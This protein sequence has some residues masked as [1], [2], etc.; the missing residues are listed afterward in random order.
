MPAA[1]ERDESGASGLQKWVEGTAIATAGLALGDDL[2]QQPT[3]SRSTSPPAA[4]KSLGL[5]P[6][7]RSRPTSPEVKRDSDLSRSRRISAA[8]PNTDSPTAVPLHFRRP[9]TSPGLARAVPVELPKSE[10]PTSPSQSRHR[11]Q[12]SN[13][14]EF[15]ESKEYRPLYLVALHGSAKVEQEANEELP[16]LPSSKTSSRAQSVEDLRVL[17]DQDAVKT[18][19]PIDLDLTERRKPTGLTISTDRVQDGEHDILDSQ[20]TTPTAEHF[21]ALRE[22]EK[23]PKPKYEFHSPSELLRDPAGLQEVPSSPPIEGLPSAESSVVGWKDAVEERSV[24][25]EQDHGSVHDST[26][27]AEMFTPTQ[28]RGD[29]FDDPSTPQGP[30]FANIVDQ[31]VIA[32]Y[33]EIEQPSSIEPKEIVETELASK[34]AATELAIESSSPRTKNSGFGDIVDA[35]VL[36]AAASREKP[37]DAA[38]EEPVTAI[39]GLE[40]ALMDETEVS[41]DVASESIEQP[42]E[43]SENVTAEEAG[44]KK[45]KNKKKKNKKGQASESVDLSAE[46]TPVPAEQQSPPVETTEEVSHSPEPADEA[47]ELPKEA[48]AE[49]VPVPQ[50]VLESTEAPDAAV[51]PLE[52]TEN[53]TVSA[54]EV[55]TPARVA[56][57]D[58]SKEFAGMSKKEKRAAKKKKKQQEQNEGISTAKEQIDPAGD[59][60]DKARMVASDNIDIQ[61]AIVPAAPQEQP[62]A[63]E[64]TRELIASEE[65]PAPMEEES[66]E[67]DRPFGESTTEPLEIPLDGTTP[68]A[69]VVPAPFGEPAQT[70]DDADFHEAV[71]ELDQQANPEPEKDLVVEPPQ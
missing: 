60:P 64:E 4:E 5:A 49:A 17:N 34:E 48:E 61:Q 6:K 36:A 33:K 1:A 56:E 53:A 71:E 37:L 51:P 69:S 11:R 10:S 31:A 63:Q 25:E 8:R 65:S 14:T 35:A 3:R 70:D 19:E 50:S 18:W 57:A 66:K 54:A 46:S 24:T 26:T 23:K 47:I 20:Q 43:P 7:S 29:F 44:S 16:S 15:R 45:K 38:P 39:E 41:K 2:W 12:T 52:S 68:P 59:V 22:S 40:P 13:S 21:A 28:E 67:I 30:G 55:D 32:A 9:P 58:D 27:D 42:T 62:E